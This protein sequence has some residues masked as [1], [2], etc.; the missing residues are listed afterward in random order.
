[1][2]HRG[3][4]HTQK[5]YTYLLFTVKHVVDISCLKNVDARKSEH[6]ITT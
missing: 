1:M 3:A 5:L 2:A 6:N 4:V